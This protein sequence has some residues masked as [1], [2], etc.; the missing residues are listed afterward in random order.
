[1]SQVAESMLPSPGIPMISPT[2]AS[3]STKQ[4]WET[5][6]A[7]KSAFGLSRVKPVENVALSFRGTAIRTKGGVRAGLIWLKRVGRS[8]EHLD[9]FLLLDSV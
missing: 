5:K 2:D 4:G 9:Q 3:Q 6:K 1:M 8:R 7:E